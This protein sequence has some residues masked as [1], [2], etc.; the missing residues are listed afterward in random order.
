[1]VCAATWS[2][3]G[4]YLHLTAEFAKGAKEENAD[5]SLRALRSLATEGRGREIKK[6]VSHRDHRE[7]GQVLFG[8]VG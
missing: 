3:L 1:M 5:S 6:L 7:K 8:F 2:A 4:D